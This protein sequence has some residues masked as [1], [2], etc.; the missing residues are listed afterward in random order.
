MH[1]ELASIHTPIAGISRCHPKP[2]LRFSQ[3]D[4]KKFVP[5]ANKSGI[6]IEEA[7]ILTASERNER[8][9]SRL[10]ARAEGSFVLRK[11]SPAN[12]ASAQCAGRSWS[13]LERLKIAKSER[14]ARSMEEA[15][16]PEHTAQK[17]HKASCWL[18]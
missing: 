10:P 12:V 7:T 16:P 18:P 8:W 2:S 4:R 3:K 1:W 6:M 11:K 13:C 5:M 14:H 17:S 9:L 15:S